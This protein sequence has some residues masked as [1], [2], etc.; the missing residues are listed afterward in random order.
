MKTTVEIT[1]CRFQIS[2]TNLLFCLCFD[3]NNIVSSSG[4]T[5]VTTNAGVNWTTSNVG[6]TN[7]LYNLTFTSNTSGY[8]CGSSG[9]FRYTTNGGLNWQG[10][11]AP[12]TSTLYSIMISGSDIYVSGLSGENMF[13]TTITEQTGQLGYIAGKFHYERIF[14][15]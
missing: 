12:T 14:G 7:T 15:R 11:S 10:T 9:C 8:V 3:T 6:T 5:Y 1:G 13:K 2:L 4:N